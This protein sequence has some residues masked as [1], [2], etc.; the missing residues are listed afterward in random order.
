M[1]YDYFF[2][3]G[4]I[5]HLEDVC[6]NNTPATSTSSSGTGVTVLQQQENQTNI[7]LH[8]IS[9]IER[10]TEREAS[11]TTRTSRFI[12]QLRKRAQNKRSSETYSGDSAL[13]S[14]KSKSFYTTS[15]TT[16]TTNPRHSPFITNITPTP[17]T[18]FTKNTLKNICKST[19]NISI[20]AHRPH[21]HV[22]SKKTIIGGE[23]ISTTSSS[24]CQ[25][26]RKAVPTIYDI[27]VT[28]RL[29][30]QSL[31]YI[32]SASATTASSS[33]SS[34]TTISTSKTTKKKERGFLSH[35]IRTH[36]RKAS[37]DEKD[38]GSGSGSSITKEQ[39]SSVDISIL[40]TDDESSNS[41]ISDTGE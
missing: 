35:G 23:A 1:Q 19:P 30:L 39:R 4:D 13:V 15:T 10:M 7:L 11:A 20:I 12:P 18:T 37:L 16:T 40:L 33:S 32:K 22:K 29:H 21:S 27:G 38:S 26:K 31:D 6:G 5:P 36:H 28:L 34:S 25:E 14:D 2:E 24:S 8:N 41:R 17:L 3:N 9:K